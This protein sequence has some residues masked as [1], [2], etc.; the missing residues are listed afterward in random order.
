MKTPIQK[1]QDWINSYVD[2]HKG[3]PNLYAMNKKLDEMKSEERQMV[4]DAVNTIVQT[5]TRDY[6]CKYYSAGE[7]YDKNYKQ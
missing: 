2:F 5:Q 3:L 1:Y 6:A 4:I 7:Y